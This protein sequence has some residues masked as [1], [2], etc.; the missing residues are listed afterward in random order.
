MTFDG[1]GLAGE[2]SLSALDEYGQRQFEKITNQTSLQG[3]PYD[4]RFHIHPDVEVSLDMGGAAVSLA[5]KSGEVWIFRSDGSAELRVEPSVF[6]ERNRL[7]PRATKQIVLSGRAMEYATRTRWSLAKPQ[8]SPVGMRDLVE[9]E[10]ALN[11]A[12]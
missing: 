2:D 3:I 11:S 12:D 10:T 7:K 1:R 8:D 5:L 9:D 6:L 4:I